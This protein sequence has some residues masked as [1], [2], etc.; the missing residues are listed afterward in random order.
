VAFVPIFENVWV[1]QRIDEKR[2]EAPKR[3]LRLLG[4]TPEHF[5][6]TYLHN[7]TRLK[8]MWSRRF[9][10]MIYRP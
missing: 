5:H 3:G 7:L 6:V 10:E 2:N 4:D 1:Y 9:E 8:I